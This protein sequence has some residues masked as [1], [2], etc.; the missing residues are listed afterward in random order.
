MKLDEK[1]KTVR[2]DTHGLEMESEMNSCS[3]I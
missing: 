1:K 2:R 3:K